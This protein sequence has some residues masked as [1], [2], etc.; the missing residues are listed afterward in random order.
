MSHRPLT[1]LD[2]L[3]TLLSSILTFFAGLGSSN[4]SRTLSV[5]LPFVDILR[6][7]KWLTGDRLMDSY[8]AVETLSKRNEPNS[9]RYEMD[10][11]PGCGGRVGRRG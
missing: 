11:S 2:T 10:K 4:S 1:W 6:L 9:C 5:D 8:T 7:N 3:K